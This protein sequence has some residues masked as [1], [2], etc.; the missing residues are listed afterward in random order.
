MLTE[1]LEICGANKVSHST[2]NT[3]RGTYDLVY[4][5]HL[6]PGKFEFSELTCEV[7]VGQFSNIWESRD[8]P[9][10]LSHYHYVFVM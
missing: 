2:T 10:L 4:E 1:S 8:S 6:I 5:T 3:C 7:L 9:I